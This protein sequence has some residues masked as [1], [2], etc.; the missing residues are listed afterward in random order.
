MIISGTGL[1][2]S[3]I[4]IPQNLPGGNHL[5]KVGIVCCSNGQTQDM[6]P[7]LDRLHLFLRQMGV[8]PV[9]SDYIYS[10]DSVFSGSAK[11]RA[12]AL[13]ACY[14]EE[15]IEE[16]FDISGGDIANEILPYLDFSVIRAHPKRF[17]GYSDLT[18]VLNGIY[19]KTGVSGVLYQ[20]KNLARCQEKKRAEEFEQALFGQDSRLF[21]PKCRF[22]QGE[23][24]KGIAVG[25]NIRCLLKLAGTPYWPDMRGKVLILEALSG[26]TPQI[27]TYLNQLQQ[28]GV[29][30]QV[31][32]ILLGTFTQLDREEPHLLAE[33]LVRRCGGERIALARTDEIGHGYDARAIQIG[34]KIRIRR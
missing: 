7:V 5:K 15:D 29:F 18:T 16:I 4:I 6:K 34:Q 1:V 23:E 27:V 8:T 31:Q 22:I 21:S 26:G 28:M 33:D 19:A 32:G 20:V 14:E 24:L 10:R 3:G 12:G 13:M 11:E 25:G 30:D 9:Y 17:W 2:R